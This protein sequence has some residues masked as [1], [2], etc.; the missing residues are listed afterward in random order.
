MWLAGVEPARNLLNH[1]VDSQ[2]IMLSTNE[3]FWISGL[4]FVVAACVVWLAPRPTRV[5]DTSNVH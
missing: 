2:S 3:V 1:L 5:A 4:S